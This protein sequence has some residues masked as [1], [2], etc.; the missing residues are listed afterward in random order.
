M[1]SYL[2]VAP[3]DQRHTYGG[4]NVSIPGRAAARQCDG[5]GFTG[6]W[7]YAVWTYSALVMNPPSTSNSELVT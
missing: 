1:T 6:P 7:P 4:A 2:A 5:L 3:L